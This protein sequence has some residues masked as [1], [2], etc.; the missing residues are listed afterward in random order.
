ML[1]GGRFSALDVRILCS[2]PT[3]CMGL[4]DDGDD[5]D[6]H[7]DDDDECVQYHLSKSGGGKG[8]SNL[9]ACQRLM[10]SQHLIT[11]IITIIIMIMKLITLVT[12]IIAR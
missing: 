7:Y 12:K 6:F 5:D 4:H 9:L 11:M 3:L 8:M 1:T 2:A 10:M